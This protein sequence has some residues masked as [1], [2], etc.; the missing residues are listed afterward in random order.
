MARFHLLIN[1]IDK[2]LYRV[3]A[4]SANNP[5]KWHGAEKAPLVFT[6]LL[7]KI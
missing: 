4:I 1:E 3:L 2:I 5:D 6:S 7:T